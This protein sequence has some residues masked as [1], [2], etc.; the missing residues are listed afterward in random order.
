MYRMPVL[1]ALPK[2]RGYP[3]YL[4]EL[5]HHVCRVQD[6]GLRDTSGLELFVRALEHDAG[7]LESEDI[8]GLVKQLTCERT[9]LVEVLSHSGELRPLSGEYICFLHNMR[10]ANRGDA[11][12]RKSPDNVKSS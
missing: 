4:P 2:G 6:G 1:H 10:I 11:K 8:V 5:Q 9:A 12:V 3:R 7:Y